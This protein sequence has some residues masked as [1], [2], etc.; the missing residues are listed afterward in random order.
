MKV[1]IN[2]K[3]QVNTPKKKNSYVY[4]ITLDKKNLNQL[5][6]KRQTKEGRDNRIIGCIE[7]S[8]QFNIK[9]RYVLGF[10]NASK[11]SKFNQIEMTLD[12]VFGPKRD[13]L[14][15]INKQ[16]NVEFKK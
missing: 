15:E 11:V 6:I 5:T 12:L 1:L 16:G 9:P 2:P 7:R 4:T 3:I 8:G 13:R 14:P 10:T